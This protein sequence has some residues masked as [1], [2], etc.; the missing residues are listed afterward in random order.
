MRIYSD[1]DSQHW[2]PGRICTFKLA[3]LLSYLVVFGKSHSGFICLLKLTV[4]LMNL[5]FRKTACI[6]P[7]LLVNSFRRNW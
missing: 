1:L 7:P 6:L 3:T 2:L 5:K 4:H